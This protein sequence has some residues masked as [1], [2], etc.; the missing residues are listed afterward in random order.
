MKQVTPERP[1]ILYQSPMCAALVLKKTPEFSGFGAGMST[2]M[3]PPSVLCTRFAL[4]WP[5]NLFTQLSWTTLEEHSR[6]WPPADRDP[7]GRT[8]HSRS[9]MSRSQVTPEETT[10]IWAFFVRNRIGLSSNSAFDTFPRL[11]RSKRRDK[12]WSQTLLVTALRST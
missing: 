4:G 7:P 5:R 11:T 2:Q 3:P 1:A 8:F 9:V 12:R 10:T 6:V